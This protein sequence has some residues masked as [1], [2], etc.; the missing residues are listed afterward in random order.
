M[1]ILEEKPAELG[2][3]RAEPSR[4]F[5]IPQPV[6][7]S[8][9][10]M[11]LVL[12]A[13]LLATGA[14]IPPGLP[15]PRDL[16]RS[17]LETHGQELKLLKVLGV[18]RTVGTGFGQWGGGVGGGT[19]LGGDPFFRS[20]L[21][22]TTDFRLGNPFQH[23]LHRPAAR[24]SQKPP[25]PPRHRLPSPTGQGKPGT[26]SPPKK[27]HRQGDGEGGTERCPRGA[28]GRSVPQVQRCMAQVS[29]FAFLP[30]V[31]LSMVECG[32]ET[33]R[34]SRSPPHPFGDTAAEMSPP[35]P[36]PFWGHFL[37]AG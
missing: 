22:P 2:G 8:S 20:V 5:P 13:L 15:A 35:T 29:V 1:F 25:R 18:V 6:P 16:A 36:P 21:L 26:V 10:R 33:V 30:D 17:V 14:A 28:Q 12:G 32:R 27:K 24:L 19:H 7:S 31:P 23:Q 4:P 37:A 11:A 34:G 9:T 3:P